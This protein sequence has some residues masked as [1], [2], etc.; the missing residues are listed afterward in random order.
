MIFAETLT[1]LLGV[2]PTA[3]L[4]WSL[5]VKRLLSAQIERLFRHE[6]GLANLDEFVLARRPAVADLRADAATLARS[7][8]PA[9]CTVAVRRHDRISQQRDQ[10]FF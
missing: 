6:V 2:D 3:S 10:R 1:T 7:I 9:R 5:H 8:T 4:S